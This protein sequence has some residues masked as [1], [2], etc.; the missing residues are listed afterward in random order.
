M[1]I[2]GDE[3]KLFLKEMGFIPSDS[4]VLNYPLRD[5]YKKFFLYCLEKKPEMKKREWILYKQFR[6][7]IRDNNFITLKYNGVFKIFYNFEK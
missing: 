7:L 5:L 3:I 1:L 2:Y 6:Q 4:S